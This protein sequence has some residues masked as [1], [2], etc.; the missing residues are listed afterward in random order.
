MPQGALGLLTY[1]AFT[2]IGTW[3]IISKTDTTLLPNMNSV[4][5]FGGEKSQNSGSAE[6]IKS[7]F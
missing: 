7:R 5:S 3:A 1:I 6:N 2:Q 4:Y